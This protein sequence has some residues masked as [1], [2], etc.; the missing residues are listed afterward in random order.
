MKDKDNLMNQLELGLTLVLDYN[1][2]RQINQLNSKNE[3]I[4]KKEFSYNIEIENDNTLSMYLDTISIFQI[5]FVLKYSI[6]GSIRSS[7]CHN[8]CPFEYLNKDLN[9]HSLRSLR[10][11]NYSW[12]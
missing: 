11:L 9:L 2:E 4:S 7:R 5:S 1:E 6:I 10:S 12:V 3:S 8:V